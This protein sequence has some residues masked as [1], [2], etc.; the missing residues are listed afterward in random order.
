MLKKGSL[1]W[2]ILDRWGNWGRGGVQDFLLADRPTDC[3]G[4][5][6]AWSAHF[7]L[8]KQILPY[9]L[10]PHDIP[11]SRF[12]MSYV[13]TWWPR[14]WWR[15]KDWGNGNV[16]NS[17]LLQTKFGHFSP[18]SFCPLKIPLQNSQQLTPPKTLWNN[19]IPFQIQK[20]IQRNG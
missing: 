5:V 13:P 4:G 8:L 1:V 19:P 3:E 20:S 12:K 16:G 14:D 6:W 2:E 11:I 10:S 7:S 9:I 17:F 15:R 18:F